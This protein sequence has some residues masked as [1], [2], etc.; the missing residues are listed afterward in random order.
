MKDQSKDQKYQEFLADQEKAFQAKQEEDAAKEAQLKKL[1]DLC[2]KVDAIKNELLFT[3]SQCAE[4]LTKSKVIKITNVSMK[5]PCLYI[6]NSETTLWE[7]TEGM[8]R[9][10]TTIYK[11]IVPL[12]SKK[13]EDADKAVRSVEMQYEGAAASNVKKEL[14]KELQKARNT[15]R[16]ARKKLVELG[17]SN[18]RQNIF[19]SCGDCV[20]SETE[21]NKKMQTHNLLP[22]KNGVINLTTLEQ[23][24][25]TKEDMFSFYMDVEMTDDT[26]NAEE[27]LEQY[28]PENDNDT[29]RYLLDCLSYMITPWNFLKKHSC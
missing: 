20:V 15:I 9:I 8:P 28:C 11:L 29:Y 5:N 22:I 27:F 13:I 26:S 3:D 7:K 24:P 10:I 1:H 25:R 23:R 19:R 16:T 17:S 18:K 6:W 4:M 12:V 21:F 2:V 14:E